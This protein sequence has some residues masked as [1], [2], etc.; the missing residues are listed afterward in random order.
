MLRTLLGRALARVISACREKGVFAIVQTVRER[1]CESFPNDRWGMVVF[2]LTQDRGKTMRNK[3]GFLV[4]LGGLVVA[5]N[6]FAADPTTPE[7]LA[8]ACAG[9]HGTNGVSVGPSIPTLAGIDADYFTSAMQ[10]YKKGEWASTV[11]VR[12]AKPY[13][14]DEITAMGAFFAKQKF[15]PANQ[16]TD[17]AKAK[18]GETLHNQQCEKCHENGGSSGEGAGI[19]AGQ[20]MLYL[21]ATLDDYASGTRPTD[22]KMKSKVDAVVNEHKDT[23]IEA[24]VHFY[25]SKK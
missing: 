21:H 22:K 11:M 13:S 20:W 12:L 19:L 7:M 25:G 4:L 14:D 8:N 18:L 16:K 10:G 15:V 6:S 9:C 24:L 23:G 5:G 17:P 2:L 1:F 3:I